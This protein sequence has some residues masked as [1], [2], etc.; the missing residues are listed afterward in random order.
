MEGTQMAFQWGA[1]QHAVIPSDTH[2][3]LE[4]ELH[5]MTVKVVGPR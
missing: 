1:M 2:Q 4:L 3:Y 5:P